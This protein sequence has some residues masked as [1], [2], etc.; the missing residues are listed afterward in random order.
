MMILLTRLECCLFSLPSGGVWAVAPQG[1]AAVSVHTYIQSCVACTLCIVCT[2]LDMLC[3]Y[4]TGTFIHLTSVIWYIAF[5]HTRVSYRNLFWGGGNF[6]SGEQWACEACLPRG[7]LGVLP[8]NFF[9]KVSALR[10]ILV[11]FGN[12]ALVIAP[13]PV[14]CL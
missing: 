11:G 3:V 13:V 8:Q 6:V 7:G 9:G 1:K 14:N 12:Q 5:T 4:C 2:Q 10:L